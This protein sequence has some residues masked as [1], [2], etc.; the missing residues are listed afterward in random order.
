M[1]LEKLFKK[2]CCLIGYVPINSKTNISLSVNIQ[3]MLNYDNN[4]HSNETTL[5]SF[6]SVFD[7]NTFQFIKCDDL[8]ADNAVGN[9]CFIL[10]SEKGQGQEIMKT[11]EEK[12]K[13][14]QMLLFCKKTGLSIEYDEDNN[15]FQFHRLPVC[16]NIA[17]F[18]YYE[19]VCI[20]DVIFFFGGF[21]YGVASIIAQVV[22]SRKQMNDILPNPLFNCIAILSED[23]YIH[24][25]RGKDDK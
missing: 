22:N 2:S 12:N 18:S 16:D 13:N 15:N 9:H 23:N 7:L 10:N 14:D 5:L 6:V 17:L 11:N 20:N 24:I 19:Y 25:I 21:G 3:V 8:P 1:I 4:K